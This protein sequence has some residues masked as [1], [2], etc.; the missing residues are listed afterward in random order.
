MSGSGTGTRGPLPL[1]VALGL[2]VVVGAVAILL[3]G[4]A[5]IAPA[6]RAG[7]VVVNL[8]DSVWGLLFLSPLLAGFAAILVQRLL[9]PSTRFPGRIAVAFVVMLLFASLF[10]Y[11]V[12]GGG[13]GSSGSLSVTTGSGGSGGGGNNT[14]SPPSPGHPGNSTT[15]APAYTITITSWTLLAIVL[16]ISACVAAL[17]VPGAISRLVDRRSEPSAQPDRGEI[18]N[19]LSAASAA[20]ERGEDPRETIVRLYV[21]LLQEIAPRT[22]D[23]SVLTADEIRRSI[24]VGLGVSPPASEALTRLFEEARYSTHPIGP[25]EAG[26]CREAIRQVESDL[27]RSTPA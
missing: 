14:S 22:G 11:L 25:A 7:Q 23:V 13:G 12:M 21:R 26:R 27:A 1:Y 24:L 3:V 18:R 16:A 15:V 2:A 20:L 4:A 17:T 9:D 6:P 8:P 19:A 10:V 5:P